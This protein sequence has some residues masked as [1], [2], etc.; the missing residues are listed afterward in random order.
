MMLIN[1]EPD[2]RMDAADRGLQYGDGLF[3]TVLV[4]G[5]QPR[6]WPQHLSR[7]TTDAGR[8]G[9]P[10][11]PQK[12]E[13][14]TRRLLDSLPDTSPDAGN[15][16]LKMILTRGCGGRG[17]RAPRPSS[18]SRILQWH[19]LPPDLDRQRRDGIAVTECRHP[20]SINPVLAGIKHLN[21]LDQVM[22]ASEL[23]PPWDEGVMCDAEGR[24]V[25]GTRSNLFLVKDGCL[26]T[27]AVIRCGV[28]GILRAEVLRLAH[29]RN[30]PAELIDT[31]LDGLLEA[32]E[33]FA[34]NSVAGIMPV[35]RLA[36]LQQ[37]R[38]LSPGPVT[39][40]LQQWLEEEQTLS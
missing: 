15:G 26:R 32:D 33:I 30:L 34:C 9:I 38:D 14:E 36:V 11:D 25:E 29:D 1:G 4:L 18:P 23:E 22:A 13:E 20:V 39:R 28:A 19:P 16:I 2:T 40:A 10:V 31:R 12:M 6:F 27:P 17:Y 8:L 3:E 35:C 37:Y 24:L 21:R 7:L 5:G